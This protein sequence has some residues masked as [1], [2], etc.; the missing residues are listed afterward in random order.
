MDHRAN[1]FSANILHGF[2]AIAAGLSAEPDPPPHG[3]SPPPDCHQRAAN[4]PAISNLL[5]APGSAFT[6]CND[7]SNAALANDCT[8]LPRAFAPA[9]ETIETSRGSVPLPFCGGQRAI[10]PPLTSNELNEGVGINNTLTTTVAAAPR[11]FNPTDGAA[12]TSRGG[13]PLPLDGVPRAITPP[14]NS[15]ESNE[16]GGD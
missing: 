2:A 1:V 12:A 14:L 7:A 15:N 9:D 6:P 10:T 5:P 16:G 11:A 13:V 3:A 4:P 8:V